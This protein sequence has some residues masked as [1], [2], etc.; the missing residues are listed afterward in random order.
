MTMHRRWA[1]PL[2]ALTF[3]ASIVGAAIQ[4][5]DFWFHEDGDTVFIDGNRGA[6]LHIDYIGAPLAKP[7][8]VRVTPNNPQL[9]VSPQTCT[10]TKKDDDCRLI[11]QLKKQGQ[12]VYGVNHFTITKQGA[13]QG[14][15]NAQMA[16]DAS[17]VGFGV[18]VQE[19]DMP[20]PLLTQLSRGFDEGGDRTIA[21]TVLS[22]STNSSRDYQADLSYSRRGDTNNTI[23]VKSYTIRLEPDAYCYADI[24]IDPDPNYVL[25]PI[26]VI[27]TTRSLPGNYYL[28]DVTNPS[29]PI[30]NGVYV[31]AAFNITTCSAQGENACASNRWGSMMIGL[32][33][34]GSNDLSGGLRSGQVETLRDNSWGS[35][36]GSKNSFIYYE[37]DWS[38]ENLAL[39]LIQ[40]S[41]D[42]SENWDAKAAAPSI[43]EI[44]SAPPC[45]YYLKADP[46]VVY[47]VS[48]KVFGPG[49]ITMP[50]G[51]QCQKYSTPGLDF[52]YCTGGGYKN[53]WYEVTAIPD[54]GKTFKGWYSSGLCDDASTTCRF[55][56]TRDVTLS[57]TF[58]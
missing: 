39:L 53:S 21:R 4:N 38:K 18:G 17:T 1:L 3:H 51:G 32:A 35:N 34:F 5:S 22:N 54:A 57:P 28:S 24:G 15:P 2:T 11:V 14:V 40:G 36:T 44:Q 12:K 13:S 52:T 7:L 50:A 33:N 25:L 8:T 56:L 48:A 26:H 23:F 41:T 49:S 47:S 31:T 6:P 43:L 19:K 30:F 46:N 58:Q 37:Q 27:Q 55:Q 10:F 42:G 29:R 9:K 45:S 16:S 20:R